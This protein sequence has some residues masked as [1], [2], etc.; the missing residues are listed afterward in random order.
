MNILSCVLVTK[1]GF[2]LVIGFIT[3]VQ[4]VTT[5]NYYTAPDAQF[6]M[7]STLFTLVYLHCSSPVYNTGTITV[8]LNHTLQILHIKSSL[9]RC[10]PATKSF[11]H[12]S[13]RHGVSYRELTWTL[14]RTHE[15]TWTR[16]C[17]NLNSVTHRPTTSLH[18]TSL[19]FTS[20]HLYLSLPLVTNSVTLLFI[21][22]SRGPASWR[23]T[24]NWLQSDLFAPLVLGV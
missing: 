18:F 2:E 23:L 3:R 13:Q 8:S 16:T 9:H 20:I 7:H 19:H 10:T 6:T 15:L 14:S 24:H 1:T 5:N 21:A 17:L 12:N 11:L 4:L 22:A